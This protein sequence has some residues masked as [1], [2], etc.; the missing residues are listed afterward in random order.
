MVKGS[1]TWSAIRIFDHNAVDGLDVAL[2]CVAIE[3]EI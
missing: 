3:N 2:P 1:E